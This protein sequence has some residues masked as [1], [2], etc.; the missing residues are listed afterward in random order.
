M[1]LRQKGRWRYPGAQPFEDSAEDQEIFRGRER[2]A[3][4]LCEHVIRTL[5]LVLFGESGLGWARPRC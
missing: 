4:R 1:D 5:L 2:D 3:S